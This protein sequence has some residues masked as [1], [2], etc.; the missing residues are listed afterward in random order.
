MASYFERVIAECPPEVLNYITQHTM[1]QEYV[2]IIQSMEAYKSLAISCGYMDAAKQ[3]DV[4]RKAF[5]A[6]GDTFDLDKKVA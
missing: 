1:S 4:A 2:R 5:S 6:V 3:V